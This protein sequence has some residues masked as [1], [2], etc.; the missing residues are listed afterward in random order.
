MISRA[1]GPLMEMLRIGE[2]V[3]KVSTM[4][5]KTTQRTKTILSVGAG[6]VSAAAGWVTY[7]AFFMESRHLEGE[8]TALMDEETQV[9]AEEQRLQKPPWF[10]HV[11]HGVAF[12]GAGFGIGYV[13][14]YRRWMQLV[15]SIR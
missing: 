11:L 13:L 3:L 1:G 15:K 5:E 14:S 8:L 12:G 4:S 9:L 2:S 7:G 10:I 6:I